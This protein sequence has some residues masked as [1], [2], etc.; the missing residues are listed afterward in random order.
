MHPAPSIIAFTTLS[1]LGFGLMA[2]LGVG[3]DPL[4]A[5]PL[6]PLRP[7]RSPSPPPAFSPASSTSASPAASSR[8]SRQWRTSWLSREAVL[9]VATFAVF[10]LFAALWVLLGIRTRWL[11]V[12]AAA[13]ALATVFATAMIYAQLRSVPRWRSPLTPLLFLLF[14]LA[15]GALLAGAARARPLAARRPRPRQ[16]AAWAHGDRRFAGAGTTLA[17]ATGLGAAR[18]A[19]APRAAAYRAR[20]TSCAR[21]S[22]SS[23]AATRSSSALAGLAL[24][25]LLP[26][27]LRPRPRPAHAR[28]SPRSCTPP[29]RS[30]CAG[31]SSRRPSTWLDSTTEGGKTLA[32]CRRVSPPMPKAQVQAQ[33]RR[34]VLAGPAAAAAGGARSAGGARARACASC[35][36]PA[37]TPAAG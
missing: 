11:G 23:A 34:R 12:P 33:P 10:A 21:W 32:H 5:A 9:A 2:W 20:T 17:T 35:S 27:A 6:P 28:R 24:A 18:P 1:G 4:A 13:L 37:A 16:L 19:A 22:T 7:R 14:A 26:L 15:G 36:S 8:P 30:S 29:G 3:A 25:V 31:S